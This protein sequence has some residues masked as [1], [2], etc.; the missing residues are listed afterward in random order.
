MGAPSRVL[1]HPNNGCADSQYATKTIIHPD[2]SFSFHAFAT[3]NVSH[4]T[5][6]RPQAAAPTLKLLI[7]TSSKRR[8]SL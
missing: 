7:Q 5:T 4:R 1:M 6:P 2:T 8:I 3:R